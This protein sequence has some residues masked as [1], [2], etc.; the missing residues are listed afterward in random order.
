MAIAA[1][2]VL[3]C[4]AAIAPAATPTGAPA[5]APT[6]APTPAPAAAPVAG[7]QLI[8]PVTNNSDQPAFLLVGEDT[9]PV[10]RAVGA[11]DPA[12]VPPRSKRMVVFTVPDTRTWAIFVNPGQPNVGALIIAQ[13]VHRCVGRVPIEIMVGG[14]GD[15]VWSSPGGPSC[16]TP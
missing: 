15:A 7:R 2:A 14:R 12:V 3:A 5:G 13:D 9:M 8:F 11:A 4:E 10:T 16:V 1:L 6:P